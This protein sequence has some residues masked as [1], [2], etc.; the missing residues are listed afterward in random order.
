M[1][2]YKLSAT[3]PAVQYG[4]I[5]PEIELEGDSIDELHATAMAHIE[6]VWAKYGERPLKSASAISDFGGGSTTPLERLSSF[7]NEEI[8]YD[9]ENHKYYTLDMV[10]L[11]SGSAYANNVSPKFDRGAILPK[12]AKAW[13]VDEAV[14]SDM[15]TLGGLI[16]TEYGASIH[17]ALDVWC[18]YKDVGA[19]IKEQKGLD[20]NYVL[21][22]NAHIR[23]IVLEF[24]ALL[25]KVGTISEVLVTDINNRMAGKIDLLEIIDKDK[26]VCRIGDYKTNNDLDDKK[27]QKYQ[28]QLS[29][30]AHILKNHGWTVQ[31][32]D[33][34]HYDGATWHRV[35]LEVLD[36]V[37]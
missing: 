1:I 17:T 20:Y 3:I 8:L 34:F 5:I 21:P 14:L 32:L 27:L 30:Y 6:K 31:G 4:N 19:K 7:T 10:P 26:K 35:E 24:D 37:K 25:G 15:W 23:D 11:L 12:T 36:L 33:I 28:H 22:K 29:F 13:G 16:S 18:K 9:G 2:K